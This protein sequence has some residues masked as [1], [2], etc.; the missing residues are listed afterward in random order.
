M[1]KVFPDSNHL[2]HCQT[3]DYEGDHVNVHISRHQNQISLKPKECAPPDGCWNLAAVASSE[4]HFNQRFGSSR[5]D[6]K[7]FDQKGNC[8]RL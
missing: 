7:L 3:T 4:A 6:L 8:P 5:S 2:P 1:C